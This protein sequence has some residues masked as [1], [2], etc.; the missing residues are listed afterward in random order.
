MTPTASK[1]NKG[2]AIQI[3][4]MLQPSFTKGV[5]L[6]ITRGLPKEHLETLYVM[7][8][9][10]YSQEKFKEALQV[11]ET[12]A[13]YNHLDKRAWIGA[14]ACSKMLKRYDQALTE[15]ACAALIDGEDPAPAFHAFDC[16]LALKKYSEARS[17][18]DAVIS[19][20]ENKPQYADFEKRARALKKSL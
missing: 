11:F 12:M 18:L 20:S 2:S 3:A 13:F 5:P 17:A 16:Y 9:N 4:E 1:K 6:Y 19:L 8:Y 14:A 7:A 15:Y 10:L